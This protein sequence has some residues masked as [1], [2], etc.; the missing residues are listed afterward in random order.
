MIGGNVRKEER[1]GKTCKG[2]KERRESKEVRKEEGLKEGKGG[3]EA[4]RQSES[5][6]EKKKTYQLGQ[7][8][9][10]LNPG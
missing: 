3:R 10:P 4:G 8:L 1:K 2:R 7:E 6:G 9:N 5:C